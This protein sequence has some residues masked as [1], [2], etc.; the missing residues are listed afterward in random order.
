[1]KQKKSLGCLLIHGFCGS[2]SE[3][4][5]LADYFNDQGI[6]ARMVVLK[7]HESTLRELRR[8]TRQDWLCSAVKAMEHMKRDYENVVVIGFSMGGLC[9]TYLQTFSPVATILIN[10]PIYFWN[11]KIIIPDFMK[12]FHRALHRYILK[13]TATSPRSLYQFLSLLKETLK[14]NR[15]GCIQCP[16]MVIQ[17]KDDETVN[18]KSA[19]YIYHHLGSSQKELRSYIHGGH[20]ILMSKRSLD[21]CRDIDRFLR[22]NGIV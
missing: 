18:P 2:R 14:E 10:C 5:V 3:I 8:S 22:Q 21:V 9:A 12:D 1:M 6:D 16:T 13:N 11:M 15:F 17:S 4:S 7:G 20:R 19:K